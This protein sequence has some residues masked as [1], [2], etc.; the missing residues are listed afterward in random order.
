MLRP[1][2]RLQL[3]KNGLSSEFIEQAKAIFKNEKILKITILKSACRDKKEAEEI[4]KEL[5]EALGKKY[6]YKL[7]GYVLTIMKF[8]KNQR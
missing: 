2:K 4:A 6:D 7:I 5:M 3:G 8:R 1:I